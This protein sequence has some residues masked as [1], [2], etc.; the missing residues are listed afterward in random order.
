MPR[1]GP[2][3]HTVSPTFDFFVRFKKEIN[4]KIVYIIL[5]TIFPAFA[6]ADDPSIN[7][8]GNPTT[9]CTKL[10]LTVNQIEDINMKRIVTLTESQMKTLSPNWKTQSIGIVSE[11]WHD[12]T[13]GMI[14]AFW[15]EPNEISV[16]IH[17]IAY[18]KELQKYS[19]EGQS[20]ASESEGW[21]FLN[22]LRKTTIMDT[23]GIFYRD[24]KPVSLPELKDEFTRTKEP[25]TMNIPSQ[26]ILN[27]ITI[28]TYL[29]KLTDFGI[30]FKIFD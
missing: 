28:N 1:A 25:I 20:K 10:E 19:E 30:I 22:Y 21:D 29:K 24:G 5:M 3:P 18:E 16:P 8:L 7:S 4:M 13:C 27:K 9:K 23:K 6:F 14:Y 2:H 11:N 15:T 12:C 17:L 26:K